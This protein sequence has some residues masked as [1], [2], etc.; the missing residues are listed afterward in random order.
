MATNEVFIKDLPYEFLK[1]NEA[2][3]NSQ[4]FADHISLFNSVK[5]PYSNLINTPN[6]KEVPDK[7]IFYLKRMVLGKYINDPSFPIAEENQGLMTWYYLQAKVKLSNKFKRNIVRVNRVT[8]NIDDYINQS[9]S[10][11]LTRIKDSSFILNSTNSFDATL[12]SYN[13]LRPANTGNSVLDI[14]KSSKYYSVGIDSYRFDDKLT[15]IVKASLLKSRSDIVPV[16]SNFKEAI[17]LSKTINDQKEIERVIG[18][19]ITYVKKLLKDKLTSVT[20]D[21]SNPVIDPN[22]IKRSMLFALPKIFA[23]RYAIERYE[24]YE[25][26]TPLSNYSFQTSSLEGK[27]KAFALSQDGYAK[28]CSASIAGVALVSYTNPTNCV[29][30][31][32]ADTTDVSIPS[33]KELYLNDKNLTIRKFDIQELTEWKVPV[34]SAFDGFI[35]EVYGIDNTPIEPLNVTFT[36][37]LVSVNFLTLT[38]GSLYILSSDDNGMGRSKLIINDDTVLNLLPSIDLENDRYQSWM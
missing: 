25:L 15:K 6:P 36:K 17:S 9:N 30:L 29:I 7:V 10:T 11:L 23:G 35:Y 3:I 32:L 37:N 21:F 2:L 38:T 19:D 22:S 31:S 12:E 28:K 33:L 24:S 20:N 34:S 5:K 1:K 27:L 18:F 14:I 8:K 4:E 16:F 13:N 26:S